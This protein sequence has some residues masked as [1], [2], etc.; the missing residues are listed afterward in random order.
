MEIN[1]IEF[2][3]KNEIIEVRGKQIPVKYK[4]RK[5]TKCGDFY[6]NVPEDDDPYDMAYRIYR[7]KHNM[8][9]PEDIKRLREKYGLT[10]DELRKLLGWGAVTLSRYENGALQDG[11]HQNDLW[12][13]KNPQHVLELISERP[14]ALPKEKIE[15]IRT[16][17]RFSY[18]FT[19]WDNKGDSKTYDS[20]CMECAA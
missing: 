11:T 18:H 14:D 16:L 1:E 10:Q 7:E 20:S 17:Y 15:R 3:E 13:L 9:Q 12:A 5:C 6:S 2:V 4:E 19:N 8:T